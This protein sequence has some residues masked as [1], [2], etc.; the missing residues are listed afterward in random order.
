M[1]I[2]GVLVP[3]NAHATGA[4]GTASI[5]AATS[6]PRSEP[7]G[8][9]AACIPD[10]GVLGLAQIGEQ[11]VENGMVTVFGQSA[12]DKPGHFSEQLT[13]HGST[14]TNSAGGFEFTVDC[15][16]KTFLVKVSGGK[17]NGKQVRIRMS[18]LGRSF[19]RGTVVSP[20]TTIPVAYHRLHGGPIEIT[21]KRVTEYLKV[22]NMGPAVEDFGLGTRVKS[23]A[24]SPARYLNAARRH[25]GV[26]AF[27][28]E[29]AKQIDGKSRRSFKPNSY[30]APIRDGYPLVGADG[31]SRIATSKSPRAAKVKPLGS[32]GG[33]KSFGTGILKSLASKALYSG[34][35]ANAPQSPVTNFACAD[36]STDVLVEIQNQLAGISAQLDVLQESV[37]EIAATLSEMEAQLQEIQT[38]LNALS[39]ETLNQTQLILKNRADAANQAY[40]SAYQAAGVTQIGAQ[41]KSA[42]ADLQF[43]GALTPVMSFTPVPPG[44]TNQAICGTMYSALNTSSG[45]N[46]LRICT[47]Y[48]A[49]MQSFA[50]GSQTYYAT[51][52]TGLV[53]GSGVPQ[54]NLLIWTYQSMMTYG[55]SLPLPARRLAALQAQTGQLGMLMDN[56]Y[57][58]LASAQMF[59]YTATTGDTTTCSN[60]KS[61]GTYPATTPITIPDACDTIQTG[62]FAA[63]VM[64]QQASSV[65]IPLDGAVA[66]PKTNYL[67]WGYPFDTT[68]STYV[69]NRLWPFYPGSQ[70]HY[71]RDPWVN[72]F[73]LP[74]YSQYGNPECCSALSYYA[75]GGQPIQLLTEFPDT[76]EYNFRIARPVDYSTLFNSLLLVDTSSVAGTLQEAGFIGLGT[77]AVG[78]NWTHLAADA[79]DVFWIDQTTKWNSTDPL[80]NDTP[81]CTGFPPDIYPTF[82]C[83]PKY[84]DFSFTKYAPGHSLIDGILATQRWNVMAP[85]L[86]SPEN[87]APCPTVGTWPEA[88]P[89]QVCE[90]NTFGFMVDELSESPD[91]KT[92]GNVPPFWQPRM[93]AGPSSTGVPA[94]EVTEPTVYSAS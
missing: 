24:F 89:A 40:Q 60:L 85:S 74:L 43:L 54:N 47:D 25:G 30:L 16:P 27:A 21:I 41:V 9:V 79:G 80:G 65:S 93:L 71:Y 45:Q 87:I 64:N 3:A 32:G 67:W 42:N 52:Y 50:S 1:L 17:V 88:G 2:A 70:Y 90:S 51:L 76:K 15:L 94:V 14:K 28:N 33:G 58:M 22:A 86:P 39:R 34:L 48:L 37:N 66:D 26:Q 35:C 57:A 78:M 55:N 56:A 12:T 13:T 77:S 11:R 44:S 7:S 10:G 91:G 69:N 38:S 49:Q 59:E 62:L 61:S 53:G 36:P 63:S 5:A 73:N 46:P 19:E 75:R 23:R 92:P 8:D 83:S 20:V 4:E 84:V 29:L 72:K 81:P 82:D 18:G 31:T 6:V 68:A